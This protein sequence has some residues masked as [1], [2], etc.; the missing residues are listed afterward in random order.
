MAVIDIQSHIEKQIADITK[1]AMFLRSRE[2][3]W[4]EANKASDLELCK[5]LETGP[6][7]YLLKQ[8]SWQLTILLCAAFDSDRDER[9]T[10]R[11]FSSATNVS[12]DYKTL[13]SKHVSVLGLLREFRNTKV[14]HL[15]PALAEQMKSDLWLHEVLDLANDVK[16]LVEKITGKS[17]V[18][19]DNTWQDEC[20]KFWRSF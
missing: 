10:L 19:A 20:M 4:S 15:I 13:E 12:S 17:L 3:V 2:D 8:A 18:G 5:A 7:R 11:K 16:D 9:V 14:A 6:A 1:T